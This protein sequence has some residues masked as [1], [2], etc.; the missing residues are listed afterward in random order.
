MTLGVARRGCR[1]ATSRQPGVPR[2]PRRVPRGRGGSARGTRELLDR[3]AE[4]QARE[5]REGLDA[6]GGHDHEA[7]VARASAATRGWR[8]LTAT[9]TPHRVARW[10]WAMDFE[11]MGW[12]SKSK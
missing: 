9:A 5:A 4:P 10:T 6:G 2:R 8:T 11:A 1:S 12:R 7:A 3:L